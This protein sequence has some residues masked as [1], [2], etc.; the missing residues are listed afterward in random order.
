MSCKENV[1]QSAQNPSGQLSPEADSPSNQGSAEQEIEAEFFFLA[2]EGGHQALVD[3]FIAE[4]ESIEKGEGLSL[5]SGLYGNLS[6]TL[7][8]KRLTDTKFTRTETAPKPSPSLKDDDATVVASNTSSA[9]RVIENI[10]QNK[11]QFYDEVIGDIRWKKE[12]FYKKSSGY[13]Q[14]TEDF[15]KREAEFNRRYPKIELEIR[16]GKLK[17]VKETARL[18]ALTTPPLPDARSVIYTY[19]VD[20]KDALSLKR[21]F[22]SLADNPDTRGKYQ[23]TD[24]VF[25]RGGSK[26]LVYFR[27]MLL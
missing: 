24:Q 19:A 21:A 5:S 3:N 13:K 27:A 23:W 12:Q 9:D 1:K 8:P 10:Q 14:R 15:K 7:F 20:P 16:Q 22:Q 18:G 17:P 4:L 6:R 26:K 2:E 11:D 25:P